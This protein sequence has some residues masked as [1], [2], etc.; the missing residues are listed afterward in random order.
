MPRPTWAPW[1]G[2][3]RPSWRV[4]GQATFGPTTSDLLPG[5]VEQNF[6]YA[7]L[8]ARW[9]LRHADEPVVPFLITGVGYGMNHCTE[10]CRRRNSSA[11]RATSAWARCGRCAARSGPSCGWRCATTSSASGTPPG[12]RTTSRRRWG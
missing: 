12:S 3:S 8:D 1:A 5:D 10:H 6:F 7:G 2:G 9:N 11:A 4:E